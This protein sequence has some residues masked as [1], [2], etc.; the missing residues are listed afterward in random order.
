MRKVEA[1]IRDYQTPGYKCN[2]WELRGVPV[3]LEIG[4]KDIENGEVEHTS[5]KIEGITPE[6]K[7]AAKKPVKK[8]KTVKEEIPVLSDILKEFKNG[9]VIDDKNDLIIDGNGNLIG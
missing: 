1:D 6:V 8:V 9:I 3:R 7:Q 4:P 2:H 5:E